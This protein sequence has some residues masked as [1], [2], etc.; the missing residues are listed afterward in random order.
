MNPLNRNPF[1]N[2][3]PN[4]FR[5]NNR[6]INGIKEIKSLMHLSKGNPNILLQ[7]FPQMQSVLQMTQGKDLKSL[8]YSKC[9]E[10]GIDPNVILNELL[11]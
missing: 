7:Q 11:S 9:Q 2:N 3:Q 8:Y 5:A 10:Q 1:M 6:F 4:N